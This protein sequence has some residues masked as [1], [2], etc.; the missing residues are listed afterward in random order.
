[1]FFFSRNFKS[2]GS[3]SSAEIKEEL[4]NENGQLKKFVFGV[5]QFTQ[6]A[7]QVETTE[8]LNCASFFSDLTAELE[9]NT[10][11]EANFLDFIDVFYVNEDINEDL[12]KEV[13]LLDT[14]SNKIETAQKGE[15]TK[16]DTFKQAIEN[17]NVK[18][19]LADYSLEVKKVSDRLYELR[20][21]QKLT[22]KFLYVQPNNEIEIALIDSGKVLI[23]SN[24]SQTKKIAEYAMSEFSDF[25]AEAFMKDFN[26][27]K[28]DSKT[29]ENVLILGKN[30]KNVDTIIFA[31]I[32]HEKKQI[33]LISIPRDL[34]VDAKKINSF[35][36]YYGMDFFVKKIEGL[37][38]QRV[39]RYVL[40]DMDVFPD[41]IDKLGG[42]DYYF[43]QPLIDPTYKTVDDGVE[44][45]LYFPKGEAHLTGVQALR[46]S[47]T[48]HTTSDFS[49]AERQQKVLKAIKDK[50]MQTDASDL[51]KIIPVFLKKV[52]T[53]FNLYEAMTLANK[54]KD[55]QVRSGGVM[56]TKNILISSYFEY[57]ENNRA[58]ILTPNDENWDL[59]K[60]FVLNAIYA[61]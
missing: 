30:E 33:T 35:Y 46:V 5:C 19:Y 20:K 39:S 42:I 24:F 13:L 21:D 49:R 23:L 25:D 47:R 18:K 36:Y 3:R 1:M 7:K 12:I 31:N 59:I 50:A 61:K 14:S 6:F 53:D 57:D 56:S 8:G 29:Y 4:I 55:Y 40:I 15:P 48:R 17:E 41:V 45:T 28:L 10:T 44:G 38:G 34:W 58:Y 22:A 11:L 54:V 32:N 2:L 60:Q 27:E 51:A 52:E 9:A 37:V 43:D 16:L 26:E